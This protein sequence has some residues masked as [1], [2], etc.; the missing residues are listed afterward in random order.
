MK[1]GIVAMVF[2][3]LFALVASSCRDKDAEKRL[4]RLESRVDE[5]EKKNAGGTAMSPTI[6]PASMKTE[7]PVPDGPLAKIEF[8][9]VD[10]DF[11]K[12]KEGTQAKVTYKFKNMGE[13]PL[14]LQNVRGSCGCTT[15]DWS[16]DPVPVGGEGFITANFNSKGRTGKQNK[17][18]TVTANTDP[19]QTVL[20]FTA[21]VIPTEDGK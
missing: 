19:A 4:A 6:S 17:T 14:V 12:I 10:H 7:E 1:H 16:K 3:C 5:L 9:K 8:E 13:T 2:M 15:P 21:E 20:K 11:G 18:V